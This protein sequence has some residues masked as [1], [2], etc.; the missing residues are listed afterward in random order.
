MNETQ[1]AN[2]RLTGDLSEAATL[3]HSDATPRMTADG[4]V[5]PTVRDDMPVRARGRLGSDAAVRSRLEGLLDRAPVLQALPDDRFVILSDLHVGDGGRGDDFRANAP[6]VLHALQRYYLRR[7]FHLVL[8]GDIEDEL[9]FRPAAIRRAWPEFF[10]LTGRFARANRLLRIAG[11]HDADLGPRG[12]DGAAP[13]RE[14]TVLSLHGGLRM[15]VFHGHQ[16]SNLGMALT[17]INRIGSHWIMRPLGLPNYTVSHS[18]PKRILYERRVYD[19]ARERG[20]L[21]VIGHTHRPLFESLSKSDSLKY[22]IERLCREYAYAA[23][24]DKGAMRSQIRSLHEELRDALHRRP[25]EGSHASIYDSDV[26][27][28]CLFNSGCAIGKRGFTAIEVR[29]DQISL[30]QWSRAGV[31]SPKGQ[32]IE[33]EP[34]GNSPYVRTVLRRECLRYIFARVRLLAR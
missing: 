1:T 12:P 19:F 27:V 20:L 8:N 21:A 11:N 3:W 13:R 6:L 29:D 5:E 26:V 23:I 32:A 16:A 10:S 33:Q 14:A 22:R 34:L 31:G 7:D 2:E 28:P 4:C 9:K 24:E 18:N 15:F 25:R 30:V 17:R